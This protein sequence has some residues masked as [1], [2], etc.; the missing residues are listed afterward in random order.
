MKTHMKL[1]LVAAVG[2]PSGSPTVR[3]NFSDGNVTHEVAVPLKVSGDDFD[4]T[5]PATPITRAASPS[6]KRR[7]PTMARVTAKA[8]WIRRNS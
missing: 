4:V 1:T 5:Q 6:P 8:P 7:S 3:V 2:T